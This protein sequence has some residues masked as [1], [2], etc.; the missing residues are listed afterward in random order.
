MDLISP[1]ESASEWLLGSAELD[2]GSWSGLDESG[3]DKLG[4]GLFF[5][6][7]HD[8]G[9]LRVVSIVPGSSSHKSGLIQ[10]DDKLLNIDS[11]SVFGWNLKTLRSRLHGPPGSHVTL[12]LERGDGPRR[13]TFRINAMRGSPQYI[14]YQDLYG[15]ANA[16]QLD[17]LVLKKREEQKFNSM[18]E[19]QL[20]VEQAKFAQVPL[21]QQC[22]PCDQLS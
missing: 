6:I 22:R 14:A 12:D 9:T 8:D 17:N 18:V 13:K 10:L 19:K 15:P 3:P 5:R 4:V 20:K 7:N 2:V 11:E 16:S 21:S 1:K